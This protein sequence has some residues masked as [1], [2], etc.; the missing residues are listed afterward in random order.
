MR[1]WILY[2]HNAAT[3]S[4]TG[5]GWARGWRVKRCVQGRWRREREKGRAESN[6]EVLDILN[7]HLGHDHL[8]LFRPIDSGPSFRW[9]TDDQLGTRREKEKRMA[10]FDG[11]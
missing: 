2:V 1:G 8:G 4:I 9:E 5:R 11:R 7:F 3:R 6:G 10:S